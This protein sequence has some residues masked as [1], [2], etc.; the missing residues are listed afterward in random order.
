MGIIYIERE[1]VVLYTL[2]VIFS[3]LMLLFNYHANVLP[4]SS[5]SSQIQMSSDQNLD[6][7]IPGIGLDAPVSFIS[8]KFRLSLQCDIISLLEVRE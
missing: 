8:T 7:K 2:N 6:R 5:Y 3:P 4:G 1:K